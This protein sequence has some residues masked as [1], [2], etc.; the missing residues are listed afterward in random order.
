[1]GS[2]MCIR[3]R[4]LAI[5]NKDSLKIFKIMNSGAGFLVLWHGIFKVIYGLGLRR[6]HMSRIIMVKMYYFFKN[7]VLSCLDQTN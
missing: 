7:L 2:E 5:I 3:D 1:M 4:F 6:G